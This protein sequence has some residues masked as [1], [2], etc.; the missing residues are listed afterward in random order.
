MLRATLTA[1]AALALLGSPAWGQ[2][3]AAGG[4]MG[5]G[6]QIG[7]GAANPLGA[8]T[9]MIPPNLLGSGGAV[10]T[11]NGLG[12]VTGGF[13]FAYN[14]GY[15]M[16]NYFGGYGTNAWSGY[17]TYG[18][19][20]YGMAGYPIGGFNAGFGSTGSRFPGMPVSN[21]GTVGAARGNAGVAAMMN[22]VMPPAPRN[23]G[24]TKARA[25]STK[26]RKR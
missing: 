14:P 22:G 23:G 3:H 19:V 25:K 20:N 4:H 11:S 15:Y 8:A 5:A 12:A 16:N 2:G 17:S 1:V 13:G 21:G 6:G 26:R 18:G 10:T 24:Q 7:A 9:S